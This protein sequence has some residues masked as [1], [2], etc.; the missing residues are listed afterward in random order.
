MVSFETLSLDIPS[1]ENPFSEV[2]LQQL[3]NVLPQFIAARRWFRAKAKTIQKAAIEDVIPATGSAYVLP[4]RLD[5]TDGSSDEY[6]LPVLFG[7][8]A[9]DVDA[10]V[11]GAYR[12][13]DGRQGNIYDALSSGGFRESLLSAI[14]CNRIF[15]GSQGQFSASRTL[16]L[17]EDCSLSATA[18][19]SFVSRAEQ[20]NT[21]VVYRDRFI[22]KLFRK[23]EPGINPDLEIGTF[24]TEHGFAHTPA[25]LGKLEY[26][27]NDGT[28]YAAGIL[29]QFVKN[30]G[31]A[32]KYTLDSLSGFFQRALAVS[33]YAPKLANVHPMQLASEQ[34]P[35][36]IRD[37]LGDYAHS[38]ALLGERTAEMHAALAQRS[39]DAAFASEPFT[40]EDA[41]NLQR[42]MQA[43][44]DIAF[45]LLRRKQAA[46]TGDAAEDA[47]LL[48]KMEHRVMDR[49]AA[50][51]D[52]PVHVDRIRFHG[53][54]H[55]G[56]VLYTG[57]DF[58]I[59]DFEGEPA[60]PLRERR[61][62]GLAMRDVA[63]MIRS[64]QYAAYAALFG[65]VTGVST[66]PENRTS[67]E[68]WAAFWSAWIGAIYLNGYFRQGEASGF[69]P[70]SADE[71]R[72]LLDS[73]V[74]QKALYEVAYEL[75]N[76]PDW[77][78]IPLRGILGLV[79]A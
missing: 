15:Q 51:R 45:E 10:N 57:S 5:Y 79:G 40:A 28:T 49:F 21:S 44:A 2:V 20:S 29:Q 53:D 65:Q 27:K 23:I 52:Q 31:D 70:A 59:I 26:T 1:L 30:Q 72:V 33:A 18:I 58:M 66:D 38:A 54:Y 46:L 62:K 64:F 34:I 50:L 63:G 25:V 37:L 61:A 76:R 74:L 4:V 14:A 43:Q 67:I 68:S 12:S 56:Q 36:D 41:K 71:R 3:A 11:I 17:P 6:M 73:F 69:L 39:A 60:R 22:L 75:N 13:A 19:D 16:A 47:H 8:G 55:L 48:L 9:A 77:V 32:W 35:P 24:L 7:D 42:D 78:Q